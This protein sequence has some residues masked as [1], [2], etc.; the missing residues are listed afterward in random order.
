MVGSNLLLGDL[1]ESNA[2][3]RTLEKRAFARLLSEALRKAAKQFEKNSAKLD[4]SQFSSKSSAV[5]DEMAAASALL[6]CDDDGDFSAS[7]L[8]D[9]YPECRQGKSTAFGGFLNFFKQ[10]FGAGVLALPHAFMYVGV[11]PGILIYGLVCIFC[12][13]SQCRLVSCLHEAENTH[14]NK[15]I[16]TYLELASCVLGK[17]AGNCVGFLVVFLELIF[18]TGWI[19]VAAQ[20][21]V[22]ETGYD[23]RIVV[24]AIFPCVCVLCS[25]PKLASL[26][27]LSAFG[28]IT[29][30]LGVFG[31][32]FYYIGKRVAMQPLPLFPKT[33]SSFPDF[34]GVAVY[35]LEAIL[36]VVPVAKSMRCK[37]QVR[38]VIGAGTALYGFIAVTFAAIAFI[39]GF[40]DCKTAGSS[41]SI[42]TNCLPEG[43]AVAAVRYCLALTMVT[44]YPVILFPVTATL[45]CFI[46]NEK[47]KAG[48]R[49]LPKQAAIRYG[50]VAATCCVAA[51]FQNFALFSSLAGGLLVAPAGYILPSIIH[52]K[53]ITRRRE[54][55]ELDPSWRQRISDIVL[56]GFGA[57]TCVMTTTTSVKALLG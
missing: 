54:S 19:I 20:N 17:R 22:D 49:L 56:V 1:G 52:W 28:L 7:P 42:V 9:A 35:G 51:Y 18:C 34:V 14:K 2:T 6:S 11:V 30:V 27:F 21:I 55:G 38:R 32:V 45:E 46:L 43:T 57:I 36:M 40:G 8:L 41:G 29:Y 12:V 50:S 13:V 47:L 5:K 15:T 26:W 23:H 16:G 25:I 3:C 53:L 24:L 39:F 37:N 33:W 31:I 10:M 4:Q 44:G 48:Q